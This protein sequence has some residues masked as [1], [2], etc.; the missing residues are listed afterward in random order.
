M[1]DTPV[2]S[3]SPFQAVFNP[4]PPPFERVSLG[5]QRPVAY[6]LGHG[7]T[8]HSGYG[9]KNADY[10]K[11]LLTSEQNTETSQPAIFLC[12]FYLRTKGTA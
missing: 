11:F 7:E 12:P 4:F 3:D 6:V 8:C 5:M 1:G 2:I 9:A 10:Y